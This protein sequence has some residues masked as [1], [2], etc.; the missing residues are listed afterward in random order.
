[1]INVL[2]ARLFPSRSS[3]AQKLL[4][5]F[6]K[7]K[8]QQR[9]RQAIYFSIVGRSSFLSYRNTKYYTQRKE[10]TKGEAEKNVRVSR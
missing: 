8:K 2:S 5:A 1:V 4:F 7:K 10:K 6:F 3:G 9:R